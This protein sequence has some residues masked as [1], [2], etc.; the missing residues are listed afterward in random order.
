[1]T[2]KAPFC[3]GTWLLGNAKSLLDDPAGAL[4]AG[5]RQVG[6]VYRLRAAWRKYTVIAGPEAGEFM[7]L[8]LDKAHL[9]RERLFGSVA[10]EFGKADLVLKEIGPK[11]ARLRPPLAMAFSRQVASPHVAAMVAA[12]REEVR[13][14]PAASPLEVVKHVKRLAFAEYCTLL[15]TRDVDFGDCL[16]MTDYL[17]NVAARLLP[18][19][20]FALPWYRRAH[21]RTYGA[22]E[23]LVR[24]VRASGPAAGEAPTLVDVLAA[25]RDPAGAPLTDDEVVS[26]AAYGIGASIGYVGRLTSFMLYE[27]LRDAHLQAD[28]VAEAQASAI[29]DAAAVRRLRVLRSVYDETLRF[30]SLA[31][32]M[33]FDVA[34]GFEFHGRRVDAGDFV[35]LS[36]VPSSYAPEHFTDPMRFDPSR[37]RPPRNEHRRSE[38][39]QPFGLGD[40]TC[41]AMGLV[42]LMCTT[43]VAG[44]LIERPLSMA[45]AD[46]RLRLTVRPLPSPDRRFGMRAGP[47]AASADTSRGAEPSEDEVLATFP[48]ADE[49]AVQAALAGAARRGFAPGTVIVQEG[50][51][52]DAFF[53]IE[54]GSVVVTR[55]TGDGVQTLATLSEGE[56]F[57]E[58]GLL[59]NAPRNATVTATT[60]GATTRMLGREAFLVMV[61]ASDLVASEIGELLRTRVAATRL[62]D[63]VPQL[64]AAAGA[65]VLPEFASRTYGPGATVIRQGDPAVEF[66]VVLDGEVVVIRE[67]RGQRAEV[68]RLGPGDYFGE[69]GLLHAAPR[70]ASVVAGESGT[71]VLVTGKAGFDRLLAEGGGR[72]GALASAMLARAE[73][74]GR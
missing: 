42:E 66:F 25:V 64:T 38:A 20:V 55:R 53:L 15:G 45:P 11:H 59:Q 17:M 65:R 62:R 73:R 18:S 74:A 16:L 10:R 51:P 61:G 29:V 3:P 12:V 5:Y 31:L 27:I 44:I 46:Y 34:T 49:P 41:A 56:W 30:H 28:V 6:P 24:R 47:L 19:A 21:R 70:N 22:I 43:I 69:L 37:C 36:P 71:T 2:D 67:A 23:A 9:T 4:T 39:C 52:A 50:A 13:R 8:G 57:G 58:A 68:A 63:A 48:G 35:V 26:Y 72:A 14:W 7:A 33:A 40:R 1:M 32:G 60:G 54:R